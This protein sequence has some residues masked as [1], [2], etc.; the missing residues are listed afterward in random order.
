M[1][2]FFC[3]HD[4][5]FPCSFSAESCTVNLLNDISKLLCKIDQ[6]ELEI[7]FYYTDELWAINGDVMTLKLKKCGF[8]ACKCVIASHRNK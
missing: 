5:F 8:F 2:G 6:R 3:M 4:C 1:W 7:S